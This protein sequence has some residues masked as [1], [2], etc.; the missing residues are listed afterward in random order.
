MATINETA[1]ALATS[2]TIYSMDAGDTFYGGLGSAGDKDWVAITIEA[3][4]TINVLMTGLTGNLTSNSNCQ[5]GLYNSSG[6]LVKGEDVF[7]SNTSSLTYTNTTGVA[8]TL[9]VQAADFGNN[10]TGTYSVAVT[11]PAPPSPLD[12]LD[13]GGSKL[14]SPNVTVYFAN[15]GEVFDGVTSLGWTQTQKDNVM[16]ALQ[17]MSKGTNLT[18]TITT[19]PADA[20]FKMV[21]ENNTGVSYSAYMNPPSVANPGVGVFNTANMDLNNLIQGSLDYFI[22]QHESGHALGLSHPHDTGGGSVVMQGVSNSG[23]MGDYNLNQG[24]NTIMSYNPGYY[25][26]YGYPAGTYGVTV[27]PMALDLALLQQK[28]GAKAENTGNTVYMLPGTNATG[29]FFQTIWDTGGID[30]IRYDGA[31]S[32]IIS[33]VAA[34]LDYSDTGGGGVSFANGIKGGFT[35]ANGV[36]IENA[37]G[38]SGNDM[39]TGNSANNI[40]QGNGG[41]DQLFGQDGFDTLIGGAGADV[42]NGGTGFDTVDYSASST[43]VNV[44]LISGSGAGGDAQGDTLTGIERIYGSNFDDVFTGSGYFY[45]NGGFDT[46]IGST[47]ASVFVGG[48]GFDTVDYSASAQAVNVNLV[49][50]LGSGGDAAGDRYYQ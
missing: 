6:A 17:D 8:Q 29:T 21:T 41:N 9:Y 42:L 26:I 24:I 27:G 25:E 30:E 12:A 19:N 4:E 36:V 3:G 22:I 28:Y 43:A 20:T 23:D 37:M 47:G 7:T 5:V 32:V 18:F 40:L 16:A 39:I 15:A 44:N 46:F 10:D 13:W 48:A 11:N 49:T 35:I 1:D 2:S 45:G 38:G 33:L 14:A 31:L 50:G 34:T